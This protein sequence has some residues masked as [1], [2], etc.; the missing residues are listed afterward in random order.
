M[1]FFRTML[2]LAALTALFMAIGF[3]IGGGPGMTIAFVIAAGMNLFAY[4]NSDKMVLSQQ[5][6]REVD[7]AQAPELYGI[8]RQLAANAQLPMPTR[9]YHRD[10]SAERLR[11][12]AQSGERRRRRLFRAAAPDEQGRD[13]GRAWPRACACEEPRHTLHDHCRHRRRRDLHAGEFRHALRRRNRREGGGGI[14]STLLA[15]MVAPIAAG[16]LQ[17]ALSRSREYAADHD[18]A[19]ISGHPL[20]LASRCGRS[21]APPAK[22]RTS[23]R[24]RT[25]RA[26]RFISSTRSA[27]RAWTTCS[28][29][30]R[31][32]RTA[33]PRCRSKPAR[34]AT[35][36]GPAAE[37]SMCRGRPRRAGCVRALGPGPVGAR[38]RG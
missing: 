27:A 35:R 36:D 8:V 38:T 9:L 4:W 22:S 14:V 33:S 3:A 2:L 12:G 11:H 16:L 31:T 7:E 10:R 20:W 19:V 13:C 28:R 32:R 25:R 6:A 23:R 1:S 18:G 21:R 29:P 17:M 26:P 34:W 5:G 24:R 30:I 15:I 37:A